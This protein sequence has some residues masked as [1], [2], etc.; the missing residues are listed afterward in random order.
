MSNSGSLEEVT[1]L[2]TRDPALSIFWVLGGGSANTGN[3]GPVVGIVA[4]E[5]EVEVEVEV[6]AVE[7]GNG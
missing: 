7:E 1:D 2:R 5:V 6:L 3:R 4:V